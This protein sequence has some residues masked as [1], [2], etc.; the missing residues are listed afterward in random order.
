MYE[1]GDGVAWLSLHPEIIEIFVLSRKCSNISAQKRKN[2]WSGKQSSSKII[3]SSTFS[4]NQVIAVDAPNL[5]P[6][7]FS[8]NNVLTSHGQS[9]FLI[10]SRA[11]R[12][13]SMFSGRSN[14]G[15]SAAINNFSGRAFL[16]SAKTRQVGSGRLK[17]INNSGVFIVFYI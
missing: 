17:I 12:H 2:D 13:F 14:R 11:C 1:Y 16:I 6:R 8:L 3:P 15:P 10:I 4:K 5:Q 7:F 9:I